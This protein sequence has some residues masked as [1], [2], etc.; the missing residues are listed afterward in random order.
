MVAAIDG[1]FRELLDPATAAGMRLALQLRAFGEWFSH[2]ASHG[3]NPSGMDAPMF[4]AGPPPNRTKSYLLSYFWNYARQTINNLNMGSN[5]GAEYQAM[6][7]VLDEGVEVPSKVQEAFASREGMAG[8]H[9][10]VTAICTTASTLWSKAVIKAISEKLDRDWVRRYLV[11]DAGKRYTA[12]FQGDM[13]FA[14]YKLFDVPDAKYGQEASVW[15]GMATMAGIETG[16]AY[17]WLRNVS[18]PGPTLLTPARFVAE[19]VGDILPSVCAKNFGIFSMDHECCAPARHPL[20]FP[21]AMV[22]P[23][24]PEG[25]WSPEDRNL[26]TYMLGARMDANQA[27]MLANDSISFNR[28]DVAE[29]TEI[30]SHLSLRGRRALQEF[31]TLAYATIKDVAARAPKQ[32]EGNG[33]FIALNYH[34]WDCHCRMVVAWG[35]TRPGQEGMPDEWCLEVVAS[36]GGPPCKGSTW[37]AVKFLENV[38]SGLQSAGCPVASKVHGDCSPQTG[39]HRPEIRGKV[40]GDKAEWWNKQ[41]I[42]LMDH[43]KLESVPEPLAD[44]SR[45]MFDQVAIHNDVLA[46]INYPSDHN[47]AAAGAATTNDIDSIPDP[48]GGGGLQQARDAFRACQ[49]DLSANTLGGYLAMLSRN[50]LHERDMAKHMRYYATLCELL[51]SQVSLPGLLGSHPLVDQKMGYLIEDLGDAFEHAEE[52]S[53]QAPFVEATKAARNK[54]KDACEAAGLDI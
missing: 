38:G 36:V 13:L 33:L 50:K 54:L 1:P 8:V 53:E 35:T 24:E 18:R 23:G 39:M 30:D 9:A 31:E 42:S 4:L 2:D 29:G 7:A 22:A 46:G 21:E 15:K 47:A 52:D 12:W 34:G 20:P 44:S 10:A 40:E 26:V 43:P 14:I 48:F 6:A 32:A 17:S 19:R 41:P 16:D 45:L 51:A 3:G 25:P 5:A 11:F 49:A 37:G 28:V 27:Y